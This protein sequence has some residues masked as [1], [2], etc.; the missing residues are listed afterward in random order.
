MLG[1]MLALFFNHNIF[2]HSY[3]SNHWFCSKQKGNIYS[4]DKHNENKI[5]CDVIRE[6]SQFCIMMQK[7]E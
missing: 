7:V 5:K 3:Y 2:V 6:G 1:I 4:I